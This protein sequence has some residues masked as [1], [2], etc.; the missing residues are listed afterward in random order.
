MKIERHRMGTVEV[1]TPSG[2]LVDEDAVKFGK[3]LRERLASPNPRLC[4]AMHEVPYMDGQAL[5][6]LLDAADELNDRALVLKLA[7][8][9]P[10]CR[11]ILELTGLASRFRYFKDVQDAVRSFL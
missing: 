10:T 6:G 7:G 5:E 3:L 8:V 1:L 2:P 4:A 9:T 11:E